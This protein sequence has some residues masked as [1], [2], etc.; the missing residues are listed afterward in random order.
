M[1]DEQRLQRHT[2]ID[3][4]FGIAQRCDRVDAMFGKERADEISGIE[5]P[6][7]LSAAVRLYARHLEHARDEIGPMAGRIAAPAEYLSGAQPAT[8]TDIVKRGQRRA[9]QSVS[10]RHVTRRTGCAARRQVRRHD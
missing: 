1:A 3:A 9:A 10:Q 4:Q 7:D 8:T 2:W 6:D 5:Q